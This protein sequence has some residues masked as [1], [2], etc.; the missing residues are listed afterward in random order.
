MTLSNGLLTKTL[1]GSLTVIGILL[2]LI[3]ADIKSVQAD[4][5]AK[6]ELKA[7]YTDLL[8]LEDKIDK[9]ID[10]LISNPCNLEEEGGVS[11]NE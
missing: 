1:F 3:Y 6:I 11:P 5:K 2:S 4:N 10:Y 9:L 7:N 8:R